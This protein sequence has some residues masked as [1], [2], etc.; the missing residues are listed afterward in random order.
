[1]LR[2][3]SHGAREPLYG[4]LVTVSLFLEEIDKGIEGRPHT[5]FLFWHKN[6]VE[7]NPLSLI[8]G[9]HNRRQNIFFEFK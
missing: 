5:V 1:M 3:K 6:T 7:V 2:Q 4:P 9:V 8:N